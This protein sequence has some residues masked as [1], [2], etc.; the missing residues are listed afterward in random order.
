MQGIVELPLKIPGELRMLEI[1]R[2]NL[3]M[4]GGYGKRRVFMPGPATT[5]SGRCLHRIATRVKR[6]LDWRHDEI[7]NRRTIQESKD[8]R[9]HVP[10][11]QR[12]QQ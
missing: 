6:P 3:E 5:A 1:A 9:E 10:V 2:V 8:Q 7:E 11:R 4:I 12:R